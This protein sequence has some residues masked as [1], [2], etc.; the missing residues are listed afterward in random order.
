[1]S[2]IADINKLAAHIDFGKVIKVLAAQRTILVDANLPADTPSTDVVA[3]ENPP[4]QMTVGDVE[5]ATRSELDGKIRFLCPIKFTVMPDDIKQVKYP[6][7][8]APKNVFMNTT[9]T[10]NVAINLT[11]NSMSPTQVPAMGKQLEPVLR[12]SASAWNGTDERN[13]G[14][15]KW[16]VYDY[17]VQAADTEIRNLTAMTSLNNRMLLISFNTTAD[18]ESRWWPVGETIL[19]S[20]RL[21]SR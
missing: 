15:V 21:A 18:D 12:G 5:L 7:G 17:K 6:T 10:V 2:D 19:N 8:Q 1:M 13:I 16:V 3:P 9:A 11:Q 14:G 20:M 4:Q